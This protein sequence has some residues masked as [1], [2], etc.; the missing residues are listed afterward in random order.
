MK[1]KALSLP[2]VE[3]VRQW[4]NSQPDILRTPFPLTKEQQ[5]QFYRDVVCNRQANARFWGIWIP[6]QIEAYDVYSEKKTVDIEVLIGMAGLENIQWENRLA[7][8]SLILSPEHADHTACACMAE[9]LQMLLHEG[10][11]NLNLENIYTEVY[12]CSHIHRF[13]VESANRYNAK[14]VILP[15]RKYYNG[16][17]HDSYYINFSK[18]RYHENTVS[19]SPQETD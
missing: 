2:V 3:Q 10:F 13:W 5:E 6:T 7:E 18:E 16:K 15:N 12:E 17:Y 1:F 19:E 9:A 4:R 8:I 11:N 14:L